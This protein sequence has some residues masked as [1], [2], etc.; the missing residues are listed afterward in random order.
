MGD[1]GSQKPVEDQIIEMHEMT[2]DE[3]LSKSVQ[4]KNVLNFPYSDSEDFE[5]EDNKPSKDVV[6]QEEMEIQ[7]PVT[8]LQ[9]NNKDK[10]ENMRKIQRQL[11][12]LKKMND[13]LKLEN[14]KLKEKNKKIGKRRNK[15]VSKHNKLCIWAQKVYKG[16]INLKRRN[17]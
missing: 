13:Q 10:N 9:P 6:E 8:L 5:P 17:K 12:K 14:D 7:E 2:V 15:L 16:N 11:K 1:D 3:N 4:G